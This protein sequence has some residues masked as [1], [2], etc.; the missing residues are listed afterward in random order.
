MTYGVREELAEMAYEA[1]RRA[2][3]EA[4]SSVR[5]AHRTERRKRDLLRK[6]RGDHDD[7]RTED[8]LHL[9]LHWSVNQC[10]TI[11]AAAGKLP[12]PGVSMLVMMFSRTA[13][14]NSNGRRMSE[15]TPI[16]G[17]VGVLP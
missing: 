9:R 8:R 3:A 10:G 12:G 2:I 4:M 15:H 14:A 6:W 13:F 16:A 5:H 17:P 7:R 1:D 11:A